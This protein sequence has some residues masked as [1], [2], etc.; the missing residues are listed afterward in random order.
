MTGQSGKLHDDPDGPN[1]YRRSQMTMLQI[2]ILEAD[3]IGRAPELPPCSY[4]NSTARF[5]RPCHRGKAR[6]QQQGAI[7]YLAI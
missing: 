3:V 2:V 1:R 7:P 5:R 6:G 4:Q